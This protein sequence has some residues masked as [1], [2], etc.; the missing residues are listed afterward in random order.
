MRPPAYA[1]CG[2]TAALAFF[3]N[4][5]D[6][7]SLQEAASALH[8]VDAKSLEF[9]GSGHWYQFGQ[10]PVPGGAWPQFDVK[11]YSAT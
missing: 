6:A 8:A 3:P 1:L 11:S 10:A 5:A 2:L 7:A 4:A 9:S